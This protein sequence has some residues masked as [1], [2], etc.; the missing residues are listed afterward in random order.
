MSNKVFANGRELACKAGSGK[1]VAA[2]P[3]VCLSPPTP[4][5]GPVP[6]PY[7]VTAMDS[8][9]DGGSKHVKI[10]G[11]EVMLKDKSSFKKCTGDEAATKSL[12]MGVVTHQITGKVYFTA[13]SMD[14]KIEGENAVRHLDLVTHNH[15]SSPG[16]TGPW[17]YANGMKSGG[18]SNP[19]K[20]AVNKIERECKGYAPKGKK[21]PCAG[22]KPSRRM[23]S[24][25]AEALAT[26]TAADKC[27][28]ARRCLLQPY[29]PNAD[30][31]KAG[32]SCC[33]PQTPHH[34]I[35]ASALHVKGRKGKMIGD[36]LHSY[37]EDAAPCVCAEGPTQNVGTHGLMHTFQSANAAKCPGGMTTYKE[38]REHAAKTLKKVF[39]E[40]G[41]SQKC[42][43]A[44]LDAY[45]RKCGLKDDTPIKAVETGQT[46]KEAVKAANQQ[47]RERSAEVARRRTAAGAASI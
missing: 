36:D 45:H 47:I 33:H 12:G 10:S 1:S 37:S 32:H 14:V 44:Q 43:E 2:F 6:V 23:D 35:E 42:I 41:C 3:D 46:S 7:P 40:S 9:T 5:A 25:E 27:L 39:P 26:D 17:M 11:K 4:P 30:Q 28:A 13:W 8:D 29:V 34:L 18:G 24:G 38:A 31:K 16:N 20:G 21:D 22:G 15:M 19:C